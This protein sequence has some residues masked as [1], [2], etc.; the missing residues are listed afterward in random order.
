MLLVTFPAIVCFSRLSIEINCN[1]LN[2]RIILFFFISV[3]KLKYKRVVIFTYMRDFK[4]R[5]TAMILIIKA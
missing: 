4:A 2:I 5:Y 1:C 3:N